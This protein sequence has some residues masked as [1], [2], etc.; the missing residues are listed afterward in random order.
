[1]TKTKNNTTQVQATSSKTDSKSVKK[2]NKSKDE[3]ILIADN[4]SIELTLAWEDIHPEYQ[5]QLKKYAKNLKTDGFRR[6]KVPLALAEKMLDKSRLIQATI[7]KLVPPAYG[8]AIEAGNFKPLTQ[9]EIE[10]I[11]LE[12]ESNWV[13]KASFAQAPNISIKGYKSIVQKAIQEAEK[14]WK[15]QQKNTKAATKKGDEKQTDSDTEKKKAA[16][17][18]HT[19]HAVFSALVTQL[20]P[21]IPDL[22]I[23]DHTRQELKELEQQLSRVNATIEQFL[24]QRKQSF[25]EL[26]QELAAQTLGKLQLEFILREIQSDLKIKVSDADIT[27]EYEKLM[28]GFM[29]QNKS[30]ADAN[31]QKDN[32]SDKKSKQDTNSQKPS[33]PPMT[34]SSREYIER[35]LERKALLEALV[36]V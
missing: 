3:Q 20:K 23:R 34:E 12:W 18:E 33:I 31:T 13:L 7:E 2:T 9:P 16:Q 10:P 21:A 27:A 26:T 22:L 36:K 11:S 29:Q 6:G 1:M 15:E 5:T 4:T 8:K 24:E 17:R 32:A 28:Q 30:G 19:L 35:T 14:T 25:Q